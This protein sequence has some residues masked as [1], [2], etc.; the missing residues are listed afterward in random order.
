MALVVAAI[1]ISA[2][3]QAII[4]GLYGFGAHQQAI[5]LWQ[6]FD[7]HVHPL[8]VFVL[9]L[10]LP[11]TLP[12]YTG[13]MMPWVL[14]LVF[15]A[16]VILFATAL[17]NWAVRLKKAADKVEETLNFQAPLLMQMASFG[18][19]ISSIGRVSG[20]GN[21]VNATNSITHVLRDA[22]EQSLAT[23][24]WWPLI[25]AIGAAVLSKMMHLS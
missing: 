5:G 21:T 10:P 17:K 4:R 13:D 7:Q 24:L 6:F 9:V 14:T 1:V 19:Q 12:H 16:G 22:E 3:L 8:W 25:V 2:L 18:G 23:K 11:K 20:N 15:Y